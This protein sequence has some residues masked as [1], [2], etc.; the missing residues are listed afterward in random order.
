MATVGKTPFKIS[1]LWQES[2]KELQSKLETRTFE[3]EDT[4][5]SYDGQ[6]LGGFRHGQGTIIFKDG[7]SYTGQWYLGFA[8]GYGKFA[9]MKGETYE[10]EWYANMRHGKGLAIH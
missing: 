6:W 9:H 2:E 1:L 7:A 10:G 3:Y 8:T 4:G 5:S